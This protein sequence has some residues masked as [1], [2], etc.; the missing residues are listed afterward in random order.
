MT[1]RAL[2]FSLMAAVLVMAGCAGMVVS[3]YAGKPAPEFRIT[4]ATGEEV[5]LSQFRGRPVVLGFGASWCAH[6]KAEIPALK[7]VHAKY[8]DRVALLIAVIRSPEAEVR[9]TIMQHNLRF[10]VGLDPE[11]EVAKLYGVKGIP[12]TF[13]I[14]RNGIVAGDY[15]GEMTEGMLSDRI[16]GLLEAR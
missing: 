15:F 7:A 1:K 16:D 2:V 12:V 13:F 10:M 6:C 9:S 3:Q 4:L 5:S 14:D 11:S 8:G